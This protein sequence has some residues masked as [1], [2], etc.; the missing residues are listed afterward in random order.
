MHR[1]GIALKT[2]GAAKHAANRMDLFHRLFAGTGDGSMP[3]AG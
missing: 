2:Y 1:L 3:Y